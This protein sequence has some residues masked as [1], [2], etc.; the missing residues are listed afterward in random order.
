MALAEVVSDLSI[1]DELRSVSSWSVSSELIDT[2]WYTNSELIDA[3]WSTSS[4]LIDTKWSTSSEL[5]DLHR[6]PMSS[7]VVS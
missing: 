5:I 7:E 2:K 4:E 6:R 1:G 3:K